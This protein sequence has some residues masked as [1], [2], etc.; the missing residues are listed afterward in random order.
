MLVNPG[1]TTLTSIPGKLGTF[2]ERL[3]FVLTATVE[4]KV[5]VYRTVGK[6]KGRLDSY[7]FTCLIG[8][9]S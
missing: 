9:S 3:S 7:T 2:R 1:F 4:K 8:S 6:H 5:N